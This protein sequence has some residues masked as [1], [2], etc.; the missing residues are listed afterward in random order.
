[1]TSTQAISPFT[2]QR[3]PDLS[4]IRAPVYIIASDIETRVTD[5]KERDEQQEKQK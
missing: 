4:G 3:L 2:A 5:E 1:M